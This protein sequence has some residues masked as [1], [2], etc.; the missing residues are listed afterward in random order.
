M[1]IRRGC[2]PAG[3]IF[4]GCRR[5][6]VRHQPAESGFRLWKE[7][8]FAGCRYTPGLGGRGA[9]VRGGGAEP[10]RLTEL[11]DGPGACCGRPRRR[12]RARRRPRMGA[13]RPCPRAR[14][15]MPCRL[16]RAAAALQRG[17]RF[18]HLG[19]NWF[20][21]RTEGVW[22]AP[23]LVSRPRKKPTKQ[24]RERADGSRG[25]KCRASPRERRVTGQDVSS[26]WTEAGGE[27]PCP[28]RDHRART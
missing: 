2:A 11:R 15:R 27:P 28:G 23:W 21:R 7:W 10:F 20:R 26:G 25:L 18:A 17:R 6:G 1:P 19:A 22:C 4:Q 5:S 3:N 16:T 13:G 12:D 9:R 24:K 8:A 14:A